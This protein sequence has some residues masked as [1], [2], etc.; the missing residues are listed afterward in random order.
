[1]MKKL[2]WLALAV[3]AWAT[4]GAC[5]GKQLVPADIAKMMSTEPGQLLLQSIEG[6]GG[7]WRWRQ[8]TFVQ[9][10]YM[11]LS[12]KRGMDTV[13]T[14]RRR[15]T[16]ITP[17]IDTVDNMR[18]RMVMDLGGKG[19]F[20]EGISQAPRMLAGDNGDSVWVVVD[21]VPSTDTLRLEQAGRILKQARF[22]FAIPFALLDTTLALQRV[23]ELST[24]DTVVQKGKEPGTFDTTLTPY[25]LNKLRVEFGNR[26]A[27]RLWYVLFVDGRDGKVRRVLSPAMD[28]S[29]P[30]ITLFTDVQ[31]QF[32]L[33]VGGRRLTYPADEAGNVTGPLASEERFYSVDFMRTLETSPF[34]WVPGRTPAA[35]TTM[36]QATP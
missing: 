11:M 27:P 36:P 17:R 6:H 24:V 31:S 21:G 9:V 26:P 15:D 14:N 34:T 22:D 20:L 16:A 8:R 32:G 19:I 4:V 10:D 3:G 35:D 2:W 25:V 33:L 30:E 1:M 13:V 29:G 12:L 23:G 5:G 28:G 7:I 18:G